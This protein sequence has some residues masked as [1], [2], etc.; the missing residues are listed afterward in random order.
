[1]DLWVEKVGW[2]SVHEAEDVVYS[3]FIALAEDLK[4]RVTPVGEEHHVV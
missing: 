4:R 2:F 1:L 3:T